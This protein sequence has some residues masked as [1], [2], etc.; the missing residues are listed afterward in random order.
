MLGR[1]STRT[2]RCVDAGSTF[3]GRAF[4]FF[5][6]VVVVR[7]P[8]LRRPTP[9]WQTLLAA[10]PVLAR[11]EKGRWWLG[12][13][14]MHLRWLLSFAERTPRAAPR[15][16]FVLRFLFSLG[17]LANAE[18]IVDDIKM[19]NDDK[20]NKFWTSA[21]T[22]LNRAAN[23]GMPR[24]LTQPDRQPQPTL[25][26]RKYIPLENKR[27]HA[28]AR[29]NNAGDGPAI[30]GSRHPRLAALRQSALSGLHH[31]SR[32]LFLRLSFLSAVSFS[33]SGFGPVDLPTNPCSL[34]QIPL[35][36]F[37]RKETQNVQKC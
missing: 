1:F 16:W 30:A 18:K 24:E 34:F 27:S 2:C 6:V 26:K 4:A 15:A 37:D 22:K 32:L 7:P 23:A 5:V 8:L 14:E 20:E 29:E 25:P 28:G 33:R 10:T 11:R 21:A 13:R 36:P 17:F 12:D 35:H 3:P 19:P 9:P 31:L